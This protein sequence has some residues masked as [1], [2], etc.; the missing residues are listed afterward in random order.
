MKTRIFSL[1]F[2]LLASTWRFRV[3][4]TEP[5]APCVLAFWHASM[6]ALWKYFADKDAVGV[7]SLSKDGDLLAAL[8]ADWGYRVVRGSSSKGGAETLET[9][10]TLAKTHRVLVTPDGPRGPARVAKPGAVVAAHRAGVPLV[11]C[12]VRVSRAY[13]FRKSWDRFALPLPFARISLHFH[14]PIICPENST[15]DSIDA[16][17]RS[18][19]AM[20]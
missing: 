15:R 19:D 10:T 8:L 6:T 2:R 14:A 3:S 1:L 7:T 18:L 9:M 20:P 12:S 4:G 11:F 17:I 16:V 13:V 5:Q